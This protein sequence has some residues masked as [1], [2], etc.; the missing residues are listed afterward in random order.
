MIKLQIK[1]LA[2][3]PFNVPSSKNSKQKTKTRLIVNGKAVAKYLR[4]LGVKS[5]SCRRGS[6]YME[7]YKTR[8][9]IF[10]ECM[11]DWI[12]PEGFSHIGFHFVRQTMTL[13]DFNNMTQIIQDLMV[14][15]NYLDEDNINVMLPVNLKL[16]GKRWNKNKDNPGIYIAELIDY[17]E[18]DLA[19]Y[20]DFI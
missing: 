15:G 5:Y 12:K 14:A 7:D 3:I 10:A 20:Y 2:F 4:V 1:Q 17:P 13:F 19:D 9:N 11:K 18:F 6:K 16:N 8:P